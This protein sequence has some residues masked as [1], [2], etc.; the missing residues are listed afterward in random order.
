MKFSGFISYSHQDGT[1]LT[2]D[3]YD[4]LVALLSNFQPVFDENIPEGNRI[5][6]IKE[7]LSLCDIL[8]VII[9]PATIQSIAV[10][11]EIELAKKL[12]LKIIPCKDK[13]VELD[14]SELPWDISEYKGVDF[15]NVSSMTDNLSAYIF[16]SCQSLFCMLCSKEFNKDCM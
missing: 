3:L 4:Y 13:Y 2:E 14:W 7:K 11:E 12:D 16:D 8:V 5:E 6:K 1:E 15:K 9:T 10:N